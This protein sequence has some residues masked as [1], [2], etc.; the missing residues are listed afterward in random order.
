MTYIE[1]SMAKT[2]FGRFEPRWQK[3]ATA[4]ILKSWESPSYADV[5]RHPPAFSFVLEYSTSLFA[6]F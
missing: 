5:R 6:V 4:G 1:L 2:S 3:V